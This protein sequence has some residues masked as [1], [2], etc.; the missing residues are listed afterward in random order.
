MRRYRI[1]FDFLTEEFGNTKLNF[2]LPDN[3]VV[4]LLIRKLICKC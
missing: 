2:D 4:L 3:F 1:S